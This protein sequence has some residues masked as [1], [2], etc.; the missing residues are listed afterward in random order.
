MSKQMLAKLMGGKLRKDTAILFIGTLIGQIIGGV[1]LLVVAKL[2][3]V[4]TV[5]QYN[6]LLAAGL[7]LSSIYTLRLERAIP[8]PETEA[9]ANSLSVT[10]VMSALAL[11]TATFAVLLFLNL[12]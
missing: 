12:I 2:Y 5:G 9:Q 8:I 6:G 7:I 1:A 11:G 4:E 10:A 3:E